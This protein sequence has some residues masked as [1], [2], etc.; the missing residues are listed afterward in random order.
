MT[1]HAAKILHAAAFLELK[2]QVERLAREGSDLAACTCWMHGVE[3]CHSPYVMATGTD[4]DLFPP[5]PKMPC[6][7]ENCERCAA[8]FRGSS[9]PG[10]GF[11]TAEASCCRQMWLPT[12]LRTILQASGEDGPAV[13]GGGLHQL[14]DRQPTWCHRSSMP[15]SSGAQRVTLGSC[16]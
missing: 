1:L 6:C 7:V 5:L 11:A 2:Q 13:V 14:Y 15:C 12:K 4:S 3:V 8:H 9:S 10:S 16:A